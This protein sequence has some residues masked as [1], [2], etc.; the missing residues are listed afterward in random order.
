M[1]GIESSLR[2]VGD[3]DRSLGPES[4]AI[5][6]SKRR[7]VQA[8]PGI[9]TSVSAIKCSFAALWQ[10]PWIDKRIACPMVPP[11]LNLSKSLR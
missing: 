10:F 7:A 9:R 2:V 3:Q 6:G 1:A 11:L 5:C 4:A 8:R